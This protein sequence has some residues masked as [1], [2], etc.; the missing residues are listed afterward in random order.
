[1]QTNN[2][3][4]ITGKLRCIEQSMPQIARIAAGSD[5]IVV[6]TK[7]QTEQATWLKRQIS[8]TSIAYSDEAGLYAVLE[9]SMDHIE[10]GD[11]IR[12]WIKLSLARDIL[13]RNEHMHGRR[14]G[15]IYKIRSD[16]SFTASDQL[17]WQLHCEHEH[18]LFMRSDMAFGGHRSAFWIAASFLENV[19]SNYYDPRAAMVPKRFDLLARS[20]ANAGSFMRLAYPKLI[21]RPSSASDLLERVRSH[22]ASLTQWH[23]TPDDTF[24]PV[25]RPALA[26][27]K[28]FASEPF[29]LHY[30]NASGLV[31]SN[32]LG[33]NTQLIASRMNGELVE[34]ALLENDFNA[35][36]K[37]ETLLN[38]HWEQG[39]DEEAVDLLLRLAPQFPD[40]LLLWNQLS[41]FYSR[42]GRTAEAFAADERALSLNG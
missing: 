40:E 23:F 21:G 30:I 26:F 36:K 8:N 38:Q 31:A 18:T 6:T 3:I 1:M 37:I 24:T 13:L 5:L 7:D 41:R 9:S 20:D 29:F 27:T 22:Q 33:I 11:V 39:L 28:K 19:F 25:D 2:A 17:D 12:Q 16:F 14:Y 32:Q 35:S 42:M 4:V 15:C 10:R 34:Q